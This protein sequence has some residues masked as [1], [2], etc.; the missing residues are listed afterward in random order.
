MEKAELIQI[1]QGEI[2]SCNSTNIAEIV[3]EIVIEKEIDSKTVR[4]KLIKAHFNR[5]YKKDDIPVMDI[6][7]ELADNFNLSEDAIRYIIR[8]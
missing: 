4:N 5:L 6:Y 7:G 1:I 3:Y 2:E 8:R